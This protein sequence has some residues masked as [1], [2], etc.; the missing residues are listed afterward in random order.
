[1]THFDINTLKAL[2]EAHPES[3]AAVEEVIRLLTAPA[4]DPE[5]L[6]GLLYV[7]ETEISVREGGGGINHSG[8][9]GQ[10]AATTRRA[11]KI[12]KQFTTEEI[13]AAFPTAVE[14]TQVN[15]ITGREVPARLHHYGVRAAASRFRVDYPK[16]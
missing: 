6:E 9:A 5:L 8:H 2:A 1:M 4:V 15:H 16:A 13:A 12:K 3:A 10:K 7:I 11:N 14:K